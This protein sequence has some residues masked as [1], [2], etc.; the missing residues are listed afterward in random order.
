MRT[1]MAADDRAGQLAR[2]TTA[3]CLIYAADR[4]TEIADSIV[5]IDEA[6]RW[7]FN[8]EVGSFEVWDALLQNPE[9]MQKVLQDR[10]LPELVL[11]VQSEGRGTFYT[12]TAGQRQ[13][14]DFHTGAYKDVSKPV[15]AI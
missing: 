2:Q 12:G 1:V 15:G 10:P 3:D 6:M 7:G 4:A 11:R 9:I 5:A 14:L 13:Y 8:F